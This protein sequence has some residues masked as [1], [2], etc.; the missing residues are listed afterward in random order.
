MASLLATLTEAAGLSVL[1]L[2]FVIR[3]T[4]WLSLFGV[5]LI[6]AGAHHLA[7]LS[8]LL[9]EAAAFS[10]L[11]VFLCFSVTLYTIWLSVFG[12]H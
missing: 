2:M 7:C 6:F 5:L 8:A 11:G 3:S 12:P 4:R 9:T 10:D 1:G